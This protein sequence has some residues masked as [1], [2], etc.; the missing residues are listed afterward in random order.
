VEA[1]LRLYFHLADREEVIRDLQGVAVDDLDQ[2]R[3]EVLS[4]LRDLRDE[5]EPED[6]SGWRLVMT[7]ADGTVV[8]SLDL[9]EMALELTGLGRSLAPRPEA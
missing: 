3:T 2:A 1:A 6:W 8:L 5:H 7:K 4:A 9:G